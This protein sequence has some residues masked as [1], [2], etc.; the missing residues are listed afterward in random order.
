MKKAPFFRGSFEKSS[1]S[2]TH[3]PKSAARP[4]EMVHGGR[5]R[6]TPGRHAG[7]YS[8]MSLRLRLDSPLIWMV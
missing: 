1:T 4:L 5:R 7:T 3:R 6:G 2:G 8:G